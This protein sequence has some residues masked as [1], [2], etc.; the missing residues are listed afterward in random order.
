MPAQ[1][2]REQ[3]A[4]APPVTRALSVIKVTRG[5]LRLPEHLKS[6]VERHPYAGVG[7]PYKEMLTTS[8]WGPSNDDQ[9]PALLL[10]ALGDEPIG[11]ISL[12]SGRVHVDGRSVPMLWCSGLDVP[13]EHRQ[14]G[15]GLMLLL[16]VRALPV[17]V[18]VVGVSRQALDLYVKLGW[19]HMTATRYV[20]LLRSRPI[21]EARFGAGPRGRLLQ[22]AVD[23]V[24]RLHQTALRGAFL[25]RAR[26]LTVELRDEL[27]ATLDPLIETVSSAGLRCH[28]STRWVNWCMRTGPKDNQRRLY[29][30]S[31]RSG[32]PLGYFV[33]S[34]GTHQEAGGRQLAGLRLASLRDWV[35]FDPER[36]PDELLISVAVRTMMNGAAEAVEICVPEPGVGDKLRRLGMF[37]RGALHFL[38]RA[39]TGTLPDPASDGADLDW[40]WRPA[41]GDGFVN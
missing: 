31:E 41:D 15:A 25:W 18:G 2:D 19:K 32:A 20:L 36:L 39:P 13:K 24:L 14:T 8:A 30:V 40:W 17:P 21:I 4:A 12:F 34:T 23:A 29:L 6:P 27:P 22:G 10:A 38:V 1:D 16:A 26:A 3:H 37:A 7:G 35:S 33:S 5:M 11:R 9:E 28:R